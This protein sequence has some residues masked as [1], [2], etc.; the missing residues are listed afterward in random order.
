[1]KMASMSRGGHFQTKGGKMSYRNCR[2]WV[3]GLALLFMLTAGSTYAQNLKIR[4]T[5]E[6][7]SVRSESNVGSQV[8]SSPPL[9]SVL[10]VVSKDLPWYEVKVK[11]QMGIEVTGFIHEMYVQEMGG[12]DDAET[13]QVTTGTEKIAGGEQEGTKTTEGEDKTIAEPL[14]PETPVKEMTPVYPK[15]GLSLVGGVTSGN[16]LDGSS[17]YSENWDYY[18]LDEVNESG[19]INHSIGSPPGF[20]AAFHYLFF[21]GL[22]IQVRA[23]INGKEEIKNDVSSWSQTWTWSSGRGPYDMESEWG[24]NGNLSMSTFSFNLIYLLQQSPMFQPFFSAGVS[25]FSGSS[26]ISTV[27]GYGVSFFSDDYEWQYIDYFEVPVNAEADLSGIGFNIGG[28]LNLMFTRNIGLT[29]N[30][31]YFIKSAVTQDWTGS[32]GR[33]DLINNTSYYMDVS[34]DQ[35]AEI[36][37]QIESLE[38]NPSFFKIQ[39]G[40]T[41]GF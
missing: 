39:G 22:G 5:V 16:F 20:G 33:Y 12:T 1:M 17:S 26:D 10:E 35:A 13:T 41:I 3:W 19:S 31:I 2:K 34:A 18:A 25:Y 27:R 8:I 9:G 29:I 40:I 30:G 4:V 6:N 23:D 38:I 7:A 21:G 14:P 15:A 28:G 32:G 36:A 11:T 24:V 37:A